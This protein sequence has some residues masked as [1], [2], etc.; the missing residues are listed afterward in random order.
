ADAVWATHVVHP[1][2]A[3]ITDL[4]PD[5]IQNYDG[6]VKRQWVPEIGLFWQIGHDDG[7][8][9]NITSR[10]TKDIVRG[11]P[12]YRPSFNAYMWADAQAIA[13]IADLAGDKPTA[14]KYRAKA[15]ALKAKLQ[16][17][18]WDPQRDFFFH[19]FK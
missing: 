1:D 16:S 9:Y 11:A 17:L 12:G 7:M 5:L 15:D 19:M 4:L 10:Q 2:K 14:A 13:Q 6:W 18:L 8:E 3:F